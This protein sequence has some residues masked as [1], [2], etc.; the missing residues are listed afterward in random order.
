MPYRKT[1]RARSRIRQRRISAGG[2]LKSL[3]KNGDAA[4]AYR[5]AIS[6]QPDLFEAHYNLANLLREQGD[7][8]RG[9]EF[10]SRRRLRCGPTI[11]RRTTIWASR[12]RCWVASTTPSRRI[13]RHCRC[14]RNSLV[15]IAISAERCRRCSVTTKPSPASK[16]PSRCSPTSSRRST[17]SGT[18]TI[19]TRRCRSI[20]ELSRSIPTMHRRDGASR[21]RELPLQ[22]ITIRKQV[23]RPTFETALAELD[24]WFDATHI[25]EGVNAVGSLQPFLIAYQERTT[26]ICSPVWKIVRAPDEALAGCAGSRPGRGGEEASCASGSSPR[27]FAIIGMERDRPRLVPA[28]G[29]R[30][31]LAARVPPGRRKDRE[32]AFARSR[33]AHFE[34]NARGLRQWAEAILDQR[35][36]VLIYPEIGMD[37]TTVKLASLRL[38][39]VQVATWGIRRRPG[40]RRSTTTS[41]RRVWSP[42]TP[43]TPI[44]RSSSGCPTSDAV[45][46]R[47][48]SQRLLAT[49]RRWGCVPTAA[50]ALCRYAVQ[51]C[52]S[53]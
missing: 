14:D 21:C 30:Q 10:I 50:S 25:D 18:C 32:T 20:G 1:G 29:P 27:T 35:L 31:V 17:T 2:L 4:V 19:S 47:S 24:A 11:R 39:P 34:Q 49:T 6:L 53:I 12:Y 51:I 9:S 7:F 13:G 8:A 15:P 16:R 41:R 52:A 38:V 40:C 22:R 23:R 37:P 44:P 46:N 45:T 43:R 28:S 5:R 48:P 42:R 33:A 26:A 3:Q 36:D